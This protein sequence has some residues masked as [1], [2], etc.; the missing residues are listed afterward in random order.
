MKTLKALII[1]IVLAFWAFI[2]IAQDRNQAN[3]LQEA[4][5]FMETTGNYPAAIRLFREIATGSDRSLAARA[6]LYLGLCYE[7]L[8]KEEARKTYER[9][10]QEFADQREA[11][12]EAQAKLSAFP[13]AVSPAS[14]SALVIR[15]VL[16]LAGPGIDI[17]GAPSPDG[18]YLSYVDSE[19]G[20]LAVIEL[21]TGKKSRLTHK[22]SSVESAEHAGSP[23][24]S[25]DA[26][27]VAY[28][29]G[30]KDHMINLCTI[31][32]DGSG[33]RLLYSD[34]ESGLIYP[35]DWSPDGKCILATSLKKDNARQIVLVSVADGS[36]RVLK[37][38][39]R[40]ESWAGFSPDGRYV[41][42]DIPQ[43]GGSR[44]RDIFLLS[45]DGKRDIPLVEHP[46]ND[47]V[48][49]WAPSGKWILFSS[50]RTGTLDAWLIPVADGEAQ[51]DPQ[52]IKTDIGEISAKGFTRK[53]SFYYGKGTWMF[54]INVAAL[55][56]KTGKILI[57]PKKVTQRIV[58][59][60]S[61][62]DLSSDGKYLAFISEGAFG[63]SRP[64]SAV[65]SIRSLETG[66]ERELSL[67]LNRLYRL[68]WFPDGRSILVLGFKKKGRWGFYRIDA[69]TGDVSAMVQD[70]SDVSITDPA[71]ISPDGKT[72]FYRRIV[73][74]KE[75]HQIVGRDIE[76]GQE[77]EIYRLAD[78]SL[79]MN[80]VLSPDGRHLVFFV[81]DPQR[82][83]ALLVIPVAG[84]EAR[85]LLRVKYPE[86]I[87]YISLAWTPDG[88]QILFGKNSSQLVGKSEL[89]RI[90]VEGGEP[91]KLE[92]TI[93]N[94]MHMRVH[95]DGQRIVYTAGEYKAEIWVMENFLPDLKAVR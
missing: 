39:S 30:V 55:D 92:L 83:E 37:N 51:G 94:L 41:A 45:I 82:N 15:Q 3:K 16:A 10:V 59:L 77:R 17:L 89:W 43:Q 4:I 47:R 42:Y 75:L 21:A 76:T 8:D 86:S 35:N 65:I 34:E 81:R 9:I 90:A 62:P 70:E 71:G 31:R 23:I 5:N 88:S 53:G 74:S 33:P 64:D 58:P 69:Q 73:L 50:D 48:L 11:V 19:T 13:R 27:Q 60:N 18:R 63:S 38:L 28:S 2:L 68:R 95:L 29:W 26:K 67:E 7:K 57:L 36:A 32:L 25:A 85:E 79:V 72:I 44:Q 87:D 61:S 1:M 14:A 40:Q 24:F 22:G 78:T 12:K 52:L 6:L 54:H 20:D 91:Q 80:P 84:G 66:Q 49:G 93:D 56:L 46:A